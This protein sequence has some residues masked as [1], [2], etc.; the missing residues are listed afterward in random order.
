MSTGGYKLVKFSWQGGRT[1]SALNRCKYVL[2]G[3]CKAIVDANLGWGWDSTLNPNATINDYKEMGGHVA[4]QPNIAYFLKLEYNTHT[5]IMCVGLV[6]NTSTSV[7]TFRDEDCVN[8]VYN[9]NAS[10]TSTNANSYFYSFSNSL[11]IG[12]VKDG[13]FVTDATYGYIPSGGQFLKWMHFCGYAGNTNLIGFVR[14]NGN[15]LYSYSALIKDA[16][17]GIFAKSSKWINEISLKGFLAGEIFK[18][19][20][21]STDNNTF[22]C[23]YLNSFCNAPEANI[24]S[25]QDSN[26]LLNTLMNTAR[27]YTDYFVKGILFYNNYYYSSN[28]YNYMNSTCSQIFTASGTNLSGL[29]VQYRSSVNMRVQLQ[30]D[31]IQVSPNVSS[32]SLSPGGRWTPCY[33]FYYCLDQDTYGVV[34]GDSFKGFIDTDLLRG[35]SYTYERG[36]ALG[37]GDFLYLGGGFAVGWDSTNT[38]TLY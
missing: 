23:I 24:E 18:E 32:T 1:D 14:E 3:F 16:Q 9:T 21:H 37:G 31:S 22:G 7:G 36:Q 20:A 29:T 8:V 33:V 4:A 27:N 26:Y 10:S 35:V 15:Y 34:E 5:Y 38:E 13:T 17:I 6:Y 2:Y 11:Y 25:T 19:T 30:Y 12:I 28:Y